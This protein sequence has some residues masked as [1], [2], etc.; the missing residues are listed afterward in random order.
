MLKE[1]QMNSMNW[2]RQREGTSA[3][4]IDLYFIMFT[5]STCTVTSLIPRPFTKLQVNQH[6]ALPFTHMCK[7]LSA[8]SYL[9]TYGYGIVFRP[10][11]VKVHMNNK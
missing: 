4:T 6:V 1:S 8:Y 2:S 10:R 11:M 9:S 5:A 7:I 3:T